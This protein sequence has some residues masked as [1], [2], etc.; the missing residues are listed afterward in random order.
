MS[1][2]SSGTYPTGAYWDE[3]LKRY[4]APG[5]EGWDAERFGALVGNS[6]EA[7]LAERDTLP[8]GPPNGE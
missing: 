7:Y 1:Q 6:S 2:Q 4:V 3:G 8:C 5:D